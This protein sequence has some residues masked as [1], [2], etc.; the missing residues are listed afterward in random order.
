MPELLKPQNG[1]IG[2][3]DILGYQAFL[4]NNP[5]ERAANQILASLLT[6]EKEVPEVVVS[7][8]SEKWRKQIEPIA[9]QIASLVFSDTIL[10]T[11]ET[12]DGDDGQAPMRVGIFL[13]ACSVLW[14]KMFSFGLPVR[15][16]IHRGSFVMQKGCFAG[17][18]II[19]AYRR[20]AQLNCSASA[21]TP[22]FV[23]W[24][25][26]DIISK[27]GN[28]LERGWILPYSIPLRSGQYE[29]G[30]ILNLSFGHS[31][32][33]IFEGDIRQLVHESFFKHGKDLEPGVDVK[34]DNTE[35][36]LRF[37]KMQLE[38]RRKEKRES[39]SQ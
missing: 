26:K 18:S 14:H 9:K 24:A 34:M 37:V 11:L 4:E 30:H 13:I 25:C 32:E 21:V 15:G 8:F 36:L 17:R 12:S 19:E 7:F 35:R 6:I 22:E 23:K 3:F 1:L 20:T 29:K 16:V 38:W 10:L 39:G 31:N 2:Y 28:A 33:P 5:P 27:K